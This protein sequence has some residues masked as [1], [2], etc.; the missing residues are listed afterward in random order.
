MHIK[1][2]AVNCESPHWCWFCK[3]EWGG[4]MF[5]LVAGWFKFWHCGRH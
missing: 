1:S 5:W 2:C 3:R 4:Q